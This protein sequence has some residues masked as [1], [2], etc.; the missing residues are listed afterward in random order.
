MKVAQMIRNASSHN[1]ACGMVFHCN[2]A[3]SFADIGSD[4][5]VEKRKIH[6][7]KVTVEY[8]VITGLK[9]P[10]YN[11]NANPL[12]SISAIPNMLL[13]APSPALPLLNIKNN[14]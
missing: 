4:I 7:I 5:I 2:V 11:E 9:A 1:C 14:I 10:R 6:F 12:M 3:I 13:S 8:L